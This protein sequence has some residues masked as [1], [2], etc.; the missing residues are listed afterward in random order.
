MKSW[1]AALFVDLALALCL[2]GCGG[3]SQPVPPQ[4]SIP[5]GASLPTGQVNVAYRATLNASGGT[6]PYTWNVTSG[7]LPAGLS[8]SSSGLIS[9]M[10]TAA[11]TS[12][13][14]AQVA[15]TESAPQKATA[16]L[17]IT[18]FTPLNLATNSLLDGIQNAAYTSSLTATGGMAPYTWSVTSGALPPGLNLS[19]AGVITGTPTATGVSSF[20]VQV[21]DAESSPQKSTA[22]LSITIVAPLSITTTSVL[23]G[24]LNTPYRAN[25]AATGGIAPYNWSITAGSLPA[26]LSLSALGAITGTP[27]ATGTSTFT[28]QAADAESIPQKAAAQL[29]VTIVAPLSITTTSLLN[30]ILN[31]AYTENLDATGGVPPYSWSITTGSLPSG[32]SL[33]AAG[34]ITGTPTTPG[35]FSFTVQASDT[36]SPLQTAATQLA[37]TVNA[38]MAMTTQQYD[39]SRTGQNPNETILTP[40]NVS[41]GQFG[42]L[43]SVVV[44]GKVYAQPLYVANVAIPTKGVHNVLYVVTEHDSVYALDAD[45]NTGTNASPLWQ[46]SFIDPAHGI[47]TVSTTD[48]NCDSLSPEIGITSTPVIDTHTGTIYVLAQTKEHGQF[49]QRLHALDIATGAEKLGGPVTIQATYPGTGDGSSDGMLTFDP[50]LHLNRPG[51][52]L[53]ADK[54]YL[55]WGS[56]CDIRPAHGWIMV[57]DKSTLQQQAAWVD[58]PNG[59]L[60]GIWMSGTGLAADATGNIFLSTGNGTFDTSG[61]PVDFGDSIVKLTLSGNQL[62]PADYFTPYDQGNLEEGDINVG[63][64]GVL[65]LP[66]QSGPHVHELIEAGK[67]ASLY[68]VDR[69]HMGQFNSVDN[70]QIVQDLTNVISGMFAVPAYWNGNVYFGSGGYPVQAFGLSNGLLSATPTSQSPTSMGYPGASPVISSSGTSDG[71]VWALQNALNLNDGNQVLHA[72]DATNLSIELYNSTQNESRDNLGPVVNFTVP[73]I[74][75]GKVYVGAVNQVSVYG[76]IAQH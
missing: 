62:T 39:N 26:G 67:G 37:I 33:S 47:T 2:A 76:V 32:L 64:G 16:Q 48:V 5:A 8:L 50:L 59:Q 72:Y 10:P 70:S 24:T 55:A 49:F 41:S 46:T 53:S 56:N 71:I 9:G 17:S 27:T 23:N 58:T 14:T 28:V 3:S 22:Q 31:V 29:S 57:Y 30:G 45:S 42:K 21:A 20:T 61:I 63:S 34:V 69:D 15:D 13:F 6:A 52:L 4:L 68:V 51:L 40:S 11:G 73:T 35:T 74:A 65:L 75:N 19:A 60:G 36:E 38:L 54:V 44:D 66:D 25:L 1:K 18:I 7:S 43:F 12:T